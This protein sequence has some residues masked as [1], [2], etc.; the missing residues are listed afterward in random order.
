MT[1]ICCSFCGKDQS[2]VK[3][4][5]SGPTV[6]IC[7]ECV[8]TCNDIRREAGDDKPKKPFSK[9]DLTPKQIKKKLDVNIV[10]QEEA[11]KAI[12]VAIYNHFKRINNPKL[13]IEKSNILL[14]GP[15]G[16][17][18]TLFARTIAEFLGV[19]FVVA[20]A[21]GL[22]EAGYVGQDIESMMTQ[23]YMAAKG[24]LKAAEQ[25]I[26]FIDEIDKIART[27][28][29][30]SNSQDVG[31]RGVQRGLLKLIEGA[32]VDFNT[33]PGQKAGNSNQETIQTKDILFI[34]GGAF[35]G[36]DDIAK[37]KPTNKDKITPEDL[38]K[39]GLIPEL[40]GRLPFTV[41]LHALDIDVMTR[42][43]T[44]PKNSIVNQYKA[45]FKVDK[46]KLE[47]TKEVLSWFAEQALNRGTGARGLR[48]MLEEVMLDAMFEL[49]EHKDGKCVVSLDGIPQVD[50]SKVAKKRRKRRKR[51]VK[52]EKAV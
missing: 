22:T 31:G 6:R 41:R 35:V 8:D 26:V 18:K 36:L 51:K 24:N 42:I 2:E 11:K 19:P 46:V 40:V 15:T 39:F 28:S 17:G 32:R 29:S 20:D 30:T 7:D 38:H 16:T 5:I 4:L 47:F 27:E 21:T 34:C 45:L 23:L 1:N 43:L 9:S 48:A 50:F 10:N 37:Q 14:H 3:R 13:G 12:S 44:E 52:N 49:P 25:G 33:Q